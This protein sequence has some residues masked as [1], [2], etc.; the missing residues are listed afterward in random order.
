ME[1]RKTDRLGRRLRGARRGTAR[2]HEL[3]RRDERSDEHQLDCRLALTI[4][5][6][7]RQRGH[8]VRRVRE[9]CAGSGAHALRPP[10]RLPELLFA[11]QAMSH[12]PSGHSGRYSLL[13]VK[14]GGEKGQSSHSS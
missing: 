1:E 3:R 14:A 4:A 2:A 6:R 10:R 12:L 7:H 8:R 11:P 5:D 9:C 13:F